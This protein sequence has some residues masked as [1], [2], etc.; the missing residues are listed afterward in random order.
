MSEMILESVAESSTEHGQ[1]VALFCYAAIMKR[2]QPAW[3]LLY[4][5]PN[6]GQRS[7]VTAAR[8][9]AAGVRAGF[10][11]IGF[12]VARSGFHG[13]F[14]EM[15]RPADKLTGKRA[16]TL[17]EKQKP[18]HDSLTEQGF[19]VVVCYTWREAANAIENYLGSK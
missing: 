6:G 8:L 15:K 3:R 5:I 10:P 14:I 17:G 7:L 19:L 1:Q 11:D 9:K 2:S 18:W 16:G 13:M 12:P 4:A